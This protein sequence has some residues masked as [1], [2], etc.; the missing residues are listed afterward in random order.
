ME[1][2]HFREPVNAWSHCVWMLLALPGLVLLWRR[3]RGSAAMRTTLLIYGL[4]LVFCS[5]VSTLFH[6]VRHAPAT[7]RF[8]DSLDHI[9]IYLLIAGTYTPITWTLLRRRWRRV[10]LATVWTWAIAGIVLQLAWPQAPRWLS[11][12]LYLGMGWLA[13][14]CY[15]EIA[16]RV[17]HRALTPVW[18]GG[19]LYSLGAVF[20][21]VHFPV[22]WPGVFQ[23]H[24]L[25]HVLVVAA[26]VCHFH[27]IATMAKAAMRDLDREPRGPVPVPA[28]G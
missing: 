9:G 4:S 6:G 24:E 18:L 21:L 7:I 17:S 13:I 3:G 11:T 12:G 28:G 26:S 19:V 15:L 22:I 10:M 27:F 8:L 2:L 20:N 14:L 1:F 5:G 25:F 16:R 23:A